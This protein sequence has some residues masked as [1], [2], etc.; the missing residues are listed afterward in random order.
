MSIIFFIVLFIFC[1]VSCCDELNAVEAAVRSIVLL[2][3]EGGALPLSGGERV[4][5]F[6]PG[7]LPI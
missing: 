2:K 7:A 5:F 1:G 3:N 4:A 6:R